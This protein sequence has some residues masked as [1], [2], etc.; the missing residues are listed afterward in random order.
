MSAFRLAAALTAPLLASPVAAQCDP[1]PIFTN[2]PVAGSG[3]GFGKSFSGGPLYQAYGSPSA[4]VGGAASIVSNGAILL[5]GT[6]TF[7]AYDTMPGDQF[8]ASVAVGS[9]ATAHLVA[10]GAPTHDGI[11]ADA[12]AVYV[13]DAE[14]LTLVKKFG[15]PLEQDARFGTSVAMEDDWIVIGAPG[16]GTDDRGQVS[17]YRYLGGTSFLFD[18][19]LSAP[20]PTANDALGTSVDIDAASE[21]IIA[22]APSGLGGTPKVVVWESPEIG[23]F[24]TEAVQCTPNW[25]G[26]GRA[27]AIRGHR[28]AVGAPIDS[29]YAFQGGVVEVLELNFQTFAWDCVATLAPSAPSVLQW[30][31]TSLSL[32]EDRL[33][34]GAPGEDAA[35]VDGSGAAYVFREELAGWVQTGRWISPTPTPSGALGTA[36][37]GLAAS[38]PGEGFGGQM[39]I[40][41]LADPQPMGDGTPVANG[42]IPD[43]LFNIAPRM[44]ATVI[45]S[46]TNPTLTMTTGVFAIGAPTNVPNFLG[47]GA[48]LYAQLD[49]VI[50][51]TLGVFGATISP[52]LPYDCSQYG[53]PFAVQGA[54]YDPAAAK[55]WAFTRGY[56]VRQGF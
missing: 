19:A 27:V 47:L 54:V 50:P 29:T 34:I 40:W 38:A 31:G 35:G 55:D 42:G 12:G 15:G 28:A 6:P 21:R 22:G 5:N 16:Y 9:G 43:I 8:G 18:A 36:V 11:F 37:T 44:G 48:T 24:G 20:T 41:T 45:L 23:W 3:A 56:L 10:I 39:H 51:K 30:F 2:F 4:Q 1:A 53:V 46:L 49:V 25:T 14:T 13:Y 17:V 32:G 26:F 7:S 52:T 33:T